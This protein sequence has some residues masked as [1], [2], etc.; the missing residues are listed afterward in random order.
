MT[1]NSPIL[2]GIAAV[3]LTACAMVSNGGMPQAAVLAPR[4]P[5]SDMAPE[6]ALTC[7]L[8]AVERGGSVILTGQVLSTNPVSGSYD[9]RIRRGG[10]LSMD[11]GGEFAARAG[12]PQDIG[13]AQLSGRAADYD[14]ALTLT[15]AGR[16]VDCPLR[17]N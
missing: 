11:Q 9:L 6:A 15:V 14:T 12:Q 8:S 7:A 13:M 1:T 17:L 10:S 5:A 2:L 4:A 16:D 3:V